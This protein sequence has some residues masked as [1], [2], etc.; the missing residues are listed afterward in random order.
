MS[1]DF[2][3]IT[4]TTCSKRLRDIDLY[5][6]Y[7][8]L[9]ASYGEQDLFLFESM[10]GPLEDKR[11]SL[12][13]CHKLFELAFVGSKLT[14]TG[15]DV[16]VTM[17]AKALL[18][19]GLVRQCGD[20]YQLESGVDI[21]V[22]LRALHALFKVHEA[23]EEKPWLRSGF[24]AT[25]GYDF[26]WRIEQLPTLIKPDVA[27]P[28]L[29]L[30][31]FESV[32]FHDTESGHLYHTANRFNCK[33]PVLSLDGLG[34]AARDVA[35]TKQLQ[36]YVAEDS[37]D[38]PLFLNWVDQ[39]LEHIR[40]GDIYQIQLGHEITIKTK[41]PV[42]TVYHNLRQ[43]NPS[44]YM[45]LG[46]CGEHMLVGASPE[47]FLRKKGDMFLMRPIAGT[48]KRGKDA[49]EDQ[50][51][52]AKL[53]ADEKER[54]EHLML[55]DLCRNDMGRV[56]KPGSLKET[57]IMVVEQ[58]SHVSHLVSTI[59]ADLQADKDI[60]DAIKAT[61]PAGTMSGAPKIRA[62]EI[63]ESMEQSRR[64]YYAGA[65]GFID[66]SGEA[67]LALMIR[68]GSYKEGCYHIRASAGIVIDSSPESEW[69]ETINKMGSMYKA[70]TGKELRN[71]NFVS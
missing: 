69:L 65:T 60:Y 40:A 10:A 35:A 18:K 23:G 54:A 63:I 17:V 1:H 29:V 59:S 12:L 3:D 16:V 47:L 36:P 70:I 64:N 58:Y 32:I 26:S 50:R 42:Q 52:I 19:R 66:L 67:E 31:F 28:D 7:Q 57:K 21:W 45:F 9:L 30:A 39:A 15:V 14:I 8:T 34:Q 51:L 62:M 20:G 41:T 11:C 25:F 68:M 4:V 5:S 2:S 44:P 46:P 22:F 37:I 27:E 13:G 6:L 49:E 53:Q 56:C 24:L 55:I 33:H 38:K 61:F 71:E 43:Q 48:V